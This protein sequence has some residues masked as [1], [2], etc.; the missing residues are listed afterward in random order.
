[1]AV[2]GNSAIGVVAAVERVASSSLR[3]LHDR[4]GQHP[5]VRLSWVLSAQEIPVQNG[6]EL[7]AQ[8]ALL[9]AARAYV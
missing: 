8:R 2:V 6:S 3:H 7:L 4:L 5:S 1:M 9:S